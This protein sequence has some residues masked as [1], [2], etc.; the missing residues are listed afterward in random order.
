MQRPNI[1]FII[2]DAVRARNLSCYGYSKPTS[3]NIDE[4]A[5]QGILFENAFSCTSATDPSLTTIFSGKYP[6]S[7]GIINHG[8]RVATNEIREF[9]S[10]GTMLLPEILKSKNYRTIA[11][12][13]LGRWHKRGYDYYSGAEQKKVGRY[14][15]YILHLLQRIGK[16]VHL[17]KLQCFYYREDAK[18]VTKKAIHLTTKQKNKP[19]FLF[20][21]YWDA[22]TPYNPPEEYYQKFLSKSSSSVKVEEILNNIYNPEWKEYIKCCIGKAKTADE[23]ISKYDGAIAYIDH[24]IGKL[25]KT[26]DEKGLLDQTLLVITSDHGESLT[27]HGIYFAHHGLYDVNIH[28]P[29]IIKYPDVLPTGKRIK[30]LV[31]H[32]DILPTILDIIGINSPRDID[33]KSLIPLIFDKVNDLH[34]AILLEEA[35]TQ[36][37]R[38]IRT[39]SYKYIYALS[40]KEAICRHCGRM[41]GSLEELYDLNE[42]PD[43]NINIADQKLT[44]K[45]ELKKWLLKWTKKL[46]YKKKITV[47]QR[48]IKIAKS[49]LLY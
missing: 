10:T 3:P 6:I 9:E 43:E 30:A 12:D 17:G 42:D 31:Q 27:E 2:M 48:K 25:V 19:F 38:A 13:W 16:S 20:I 4:L 39:N 28:V 14:K 41:H 11:V 8:E 33:G 47:L 18:K 22:H 34:S 7:H 44:I 32:I 21:H 5:K 46:K 49:K 29:L 23:I 36:R 24:E 26:L 45:K 1:I 15:R 40:E 37:K 35:Y